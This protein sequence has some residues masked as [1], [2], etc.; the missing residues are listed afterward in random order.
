MR[1]NFLLQAA[2]L[3]GAVAL[4][5]AAAYAQRSQPSQSSGMFGSRSM[6]SSIGGDS[7]GSGLNLS[8]S[9][10]PTGG[11]AGGQTS[12]SERFV[13]G[14]RRSGDFVGGDSGDVQNFLSGL[15]G[16]SG[17]NGNR[18]GRS[19]SG[20]GAQA[21]RQR[22][23]QQNNNMNDNQAGQGR[24][25]RKPVRTTRIVGFEYPLPAAPRMTQTLSTHLE[26]SL[27]VRLQP[28][29]EVALEGR[30]ATL[31]GVVATDHDRDVAEQLVLLEPG[32]S[33]VQNELTVT[34]TP[35]P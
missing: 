34:P 3:L 10:R 22:Q 7:V 16:V 28:G 6:G 29:V 9:T 12:G 21:G 32:V 11:G 2:V 20:L 4:L 15:S 14:N 1:G 35:E 24:R 5:P 19:L 30:T 31:R 17:A 27:K 33:A 25:A 13:R 23:G 8:S 18:G 26:K